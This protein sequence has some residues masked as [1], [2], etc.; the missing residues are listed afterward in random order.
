VSF[1]L[2]WLGLLSGLATFFDLKDNT[3]PD[4]L[5]WIGCVMGLVLHSFSWQSWAGLG[6]MFLIGLALYYSKFFGGADTKLIA[7]TG[8]LLTLS[9]TLAYFIL[10]LGVI[11][12]IW[13]LLCKRMKWFKNRQGY[14]LAPCFLLT[15]ITLLLV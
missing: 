5:S 12:C 14:P 15:S 11:G 10:Y 3:I 4:L 8:A 1:G 2:C 13:Y 6:T 9:T 7:S